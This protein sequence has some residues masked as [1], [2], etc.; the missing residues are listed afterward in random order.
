MW[1]AGVGDN[2]PNSRGRGAFAEEHLRNG[3]LLFDS[4]KWQQIMICVVSFESWLHQNK[5]LRPVRRRAEQL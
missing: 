3:H 4:N 5:W 2:Q 1:L